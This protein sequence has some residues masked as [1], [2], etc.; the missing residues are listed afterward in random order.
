MNMHAVSIDAPPRIDFL[1]SCDFHCVDERRY[2]LK[3]LWQL[4]WYKY[5]AT[6]W[7]DGK[8]YDL[9]PGAMTVI[10]PGAVSRYRF[11]GRIRH[12]CAH[13]HF[14]SSDTPVLL[15]SF[16]APH[17]FSDQIRIDFETAIACGQQRPAQ[18][19]SL[20]WS[21]LW[22]MAELTPVDDERLV[23]RACQ[24]IESHLGTEPS[25]PELAAHCDCSVNT[26]I[27]H[28]RSQLQTTPAAY[29]RQRRAERARHLLVKLRMAPSDVA[30][31]LGFSDLQRFNKAIRA[32]TGMS[33]RQLQATQKDAR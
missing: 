2:Q 17:R 20:I 27:R 6:C 1:F 23:D 33:P 19:Q 18:A 13:M 29:I 8:R 9:K 5:D 3:G 31:E 21:V 32:A 7:I 30:Q 16:A 22:R 14:A 4:H 25:V 10:P 26:L 24:F 28:F 11:M 12:L 15:P